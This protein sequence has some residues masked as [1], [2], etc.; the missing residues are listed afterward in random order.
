MRLFA[1]TKNL[2]KLTELQELFSVY[3]VDILTFPGYVAPDETA[4][5]YAGNA[6]IKARALHQQL[7]A[8]GI[9]GDVIADDSGLEIAALGGRPGVYSARYGGP[10]ATWA[11]RRAS[12]LREVAESGSN[13]RRARFVCALCC[14]GADG[15]EVIAEGFADGELSRNEQGQLGFGYDPIF[16]DPSEHATY[17]EISEAEKNKISH[18]AKAVT[19]LMEMLR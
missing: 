13:D 16:Y 14:I 5:T 15:C 7:K 11:Q 19:L 2:G 10:N 6:A 9:D 3:G 18:R 17:G 4:D 1:A 12:L 8:A